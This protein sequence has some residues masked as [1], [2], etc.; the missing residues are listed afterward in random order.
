MRIFFT[1]S[2]EEAPVFD[3][4]SQDAASKNEELINLKLAVDDRSLKLKQAVILHYW[5]HLTIAEADHAANVPE[6][7][8]KSRLNR[9]IKQLEAIMNTEINLENSK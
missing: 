4:V 2:I 8:I 1:R 5:Q 3:M 9:S 6:G 7:T